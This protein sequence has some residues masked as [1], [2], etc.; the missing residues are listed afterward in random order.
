MLLYVQAT[1][2]LKHQERPRARDRQLEHQERPG[3]RQEHQERPGDRQEH[4]ERPGDRQVHQ[5]R[6]GKFIR[7]ED[8][9]LPRKKAH[10]LETSERPWKSC[11]RCRRL[12]ATQMIAYRRKKKEKYA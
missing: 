4:Q 6:H 1:H 12:L 11:S 9:E 8:L 10:C 7:I 5:E 2:Q 3:D